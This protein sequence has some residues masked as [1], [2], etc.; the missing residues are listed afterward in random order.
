MFAELPYVNKCSWAL[1]WDY[2]YFF[3]VCYDVKDSW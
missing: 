3:P 1:S 2:V